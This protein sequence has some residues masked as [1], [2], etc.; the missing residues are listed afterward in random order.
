MI[1]GTIAEIKNHEYRVGL[2]PSCVHA[3]T[4]AGHQVL[5][6]KDAGKNAGFFDEEY[7]KSGADI[8]DDR[9][10]ICDRSDMIVKVKEP[11]AE[12]YDLFHEGQILYTYLHLAADKPLTEMLIK[13][14]IKAVAYETIEDDEGKLPCLRPMSEIAGRLSVQEGAKY[15]EKTYGG[16]GVLLGGVPGVRRGKIAIIGG[17]IVGTNACKMAVGIGAEVNI[18]DVSGDRLAYLDDIF[19]SSITTLYSHEANIEK[20]LSEADVIIGAVLLPGRKAPCLVR[21]EHLKIMKPGAVL[22]DVAIDQGGCFETSKAT[23][24]DDP[25]YI[26]DGIVHYCVA[27]MPGAVALTSTI[28]LTSTTLPY[29]LHIANNGLEAAAKTYPGIAKGVNIYEGSCTYEP[30]ALDLDLPFIALADCI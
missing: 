5:V 25:T 10:T 23:T 22:V 7:V 29:G 2:T 27:N 8:V 14:K 24:H 9:K 3:Y 17:G 6:Q 16:R 13:N 20:A 19:G 11:I 1:I 21:R 28:G 26:I 12:E 4:R 18:L 15:L 30:V